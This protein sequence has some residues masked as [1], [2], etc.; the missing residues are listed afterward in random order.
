[1]GIGFLVI[2]CL[3]REEPGEGAGHYDSGIG[4]LLILSM[5][6]LVVLVGLLN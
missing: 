1:M 6:A 3:Y 4:V 5:V 2:A